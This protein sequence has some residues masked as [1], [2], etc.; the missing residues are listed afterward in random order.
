MPEE[1]DDIPSRGLARAFAA[2][3]SV[4][5]V[6]SVGILW[7]GRGILV[8]RELDAMQGRLE[9]HAALYEADPEAA[10]ALQSA[11]SDQGDTV[12]FPNPAGIPRP[13]VG[14][15]GTPGHDGDEGVQLTE[16]GPASITD[17]IRATGEQ[18]GSVSVMGRDYWFVVSDVIDGRSV[19]THEAADPGGWNSLV[20]AVSAVAIVSA[21]CGGLLILASDRRRVERPKTQV[22]EDAL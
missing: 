17:A 16:G 15:D 20:M 11:A 12:A 8:E 2:L 21:V 6:M 22:A 3:L 7:L 18:R 14:P 5:V 9:L 1:V 13:T 10:R 19:L 4:V